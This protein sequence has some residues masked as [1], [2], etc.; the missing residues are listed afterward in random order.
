MP[1]DWVDDGERALKTEKRWFYICTYIL[2]L[3]TTHM[4][5]VFSSDSL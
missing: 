5:A 2:R 4:K 3:Q 1:N